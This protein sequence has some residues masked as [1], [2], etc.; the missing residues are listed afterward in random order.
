MRLIDQS[1]ELI[2]APGNIEQIIEVAGRTCY[3]SHDKITDDSAG[4]FVRKIIRSGHESVIEHMNIVL[5]FVTSRGVTHELVRHRLASYSM[6]STRYVDYGI[7][8]EDEHLEFIRPLWVSPRFLGEI[9]SDHEMLHSPRFDDLTAAEFEFLDA[10]LNAEHSYRALRI[11]N[12]PPQ[13]ARDALNN[14]S[15]TEIVMSANMRAWRHI[16]KQRTGAGAHPMIRDLMYKA[17]KLLRPC[18]PTIFED[19]KDKED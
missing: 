15:K 3:K 1:A 7:G 5:R 17:L 11:N 6:E 12:R 16:I 14:A 4:A 19:I 13:D 9:E 10:C 8:D 18:A 2:Y